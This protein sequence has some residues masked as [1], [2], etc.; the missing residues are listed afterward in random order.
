[1]GKMDTFITVAGF[2]SSVV[3]VTGALIQI[4]FLGLR[5]WLRMGAGL[6]TEVH[7][8]RDHLKADAHKVAEEVE[9]L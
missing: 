7:E 8:A 3:T 4:K 5:G 2:G 9:K 1:M 6:G